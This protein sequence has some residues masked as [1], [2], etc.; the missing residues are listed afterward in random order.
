MSTTNNWLDQGRNIGLGSETYFSNAV[1]LDSAGVLELANYLITGGGLSGLFSDPMDWISS[2]TYF[3]FAVYAES[4]DM[5]LQIGP[6]TTDIPCKA[7][8]SGTI[9]LSSVFEWYDLGEWYCEPHFNNFADYNGYTK[10]KVFL[11]FLGY[12]EILPN[13]VMGK[14]VEFFLKVDLQTGLGVYYIGV[15]DTSL[16]RGTDLPYMTMDYSNVRIIS[17]HTVQIGVEIPLGASNAIDIKR[18]IIMGSVRSASNAI[19]AYTIGAVAPSEGVT[20]KTV[21]TVRNPATG[22]Q[23]TQSTTTKTREGGPDISATGAIASCFETSVNALNAF[24]LD[25]TS[26]KPNNPLA[27]V[28]AAKSIKIVRYLPKLKETTVNYTRLYGKPLGKAQLIRTVTGF[29]TVTKVQLYNSDADF[30]AITETERNMIENI[31]KSGFYQNIE[32]EIVG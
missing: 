22:R 13:D 14:Y 28:N 30:G 25:A 21:N 6:T 16:T 9:G 12:V 10:I 2:L 24:H 4:G 17:I 3:P 29:T 8:A 32:S 23:I 7:S 20:E 11:P 1:A 15:N 31:L 5:S 26:D 18:N 27:L 19:T